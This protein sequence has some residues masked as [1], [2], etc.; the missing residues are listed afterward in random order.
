[1]IIG[2][3][4]AMAE[5]VEWFHS[6]LVES[7]RTSLAGI[8]YIEGTFQGK[9]VVLCKSGVGKVNAAICTQQLIAQFKVDRILFTGV[10]GALHPDLNIGDLVIS[11]DCLQHDIDVTALGFDKGVI[12]YQAQSIYPADEN[13]R[14]IAYQCSVQLFE[15]KSYQGRVLS[16]DQFIADREQV[17]QLR[18]TFDGMCTEMEGAAVAQVCA[19]HKVPY[20]VIRSM[21]D[22]ADGS[23]PVNFAA[24]TKQAAEHSFRLVS[25]IVQKL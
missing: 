23:A 7:N 14:E 20:V 12:P 25:S 17:K 24:F 2:I 6:E 8:T 13:L 11:T 4:G 1:M 10:A 3:I 19:M 15:E 16:G 5:E 21:S 9:S 22:K 18:E